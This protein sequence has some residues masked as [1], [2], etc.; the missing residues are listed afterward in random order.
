MAPLGATLATEEVAETELEFYSTYG[1]HPVSVEA[2]IA[3]Q[4][5]WR[6]HRDAVLANVA[7]RAVQAR[8]QLS[9][10]EFAREPE[11]RIQGLAIAVG[12][13]DVEFARK[14]E[15]CCRDVSGETQP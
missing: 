4:H 9:L 2:A 5:Y 12:F 7:E 15:E 11:L 8:Q 13:G 6:E 14:L 1:W 3:T 10:M